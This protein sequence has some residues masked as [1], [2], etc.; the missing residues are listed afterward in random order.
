MKSPIEIV[1][2]PNSQ[3]LRLSCGQCGDTIDIIIETVDNK[4]TIYIQESTDMTTL[5][6]DCPEFLLQPVHLLI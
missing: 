2:D 3:L 4:L 5:K 6:D 1:L